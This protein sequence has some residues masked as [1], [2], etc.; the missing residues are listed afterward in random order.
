MQ[1]KAQIEKTLYAYIYSIATWR[2]FLYVL[3]KRTLCFYCQLLH[4]VKEV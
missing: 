1:K 3:N 4:M 2:N